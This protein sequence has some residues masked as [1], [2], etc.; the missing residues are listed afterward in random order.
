MTILVQK[1]GG[2]SLQT[3]ASITNV[4]SHIKHAIEGQYKLVVVV[5]ALG[6]KPDPYATDTLL[7]LANQANQF[8]SK[9]EKDLLMS[10]GEIIASVVLS[11]ELQNNHIKSIALTG[12]QAGI[13]TTSD[14]TEA[15]IKS[16]N[17]TRIVNELENHDVVVVAGFQGQ[18]SAG[19]VT[20]IGRGGSDTTAAVLGAA[21]NA[22][23]VEIFTDVNGIM[24]ADPRIVKS[25]RQ[26]KVVSYTEICNFA[27]QGAKVIHPRAVEIAMGANIPLHVRSTYSIEN[28]TL[29]TSA[30]IRE[31]PDQPITGIA[32]MLEL[33]QIK[34]KNREKMHRHHS[35]IFKEIED[36][37][38]SVDFSTISSTDLLLTI[39]KVYTQT[40]VDCITNLDCQP[41]V[42]ENCARI[43]VVGGGLMGVTVA[44][45]IVQ[46]LTEKGIEVLQSA[47][48]HTSNRVLVYEKD[49]MDAVNV[50]HD[51][52]NLSQTLES[53][54]K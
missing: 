30:G 40:A 7:S 29:V 47:E 52:F 33:T 46:V 21:L 14:F 26:L 18:T 28:G 35:D 13:T 51:S 49:L 11:N 3:P 8:H 53:G 48:S 43:S 22:E 12:A 31:I 9:R 34:I 16:V 4:I 25:A 32:H 24:T 38:I 5:S 20:T 37:G 1:F 23:K 44:S 42:I 41:Q 45:G 54:I 6:R 15:K 2:T 19:E 17:T 39:P 27:N 10:C 36:A 50:L